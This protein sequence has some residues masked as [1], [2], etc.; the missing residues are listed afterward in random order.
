MTGLSVLF[1]AQAATAASIGFTGVDQADMDNIVKELS[2]NGSLHTVTTPSG[3]GSIFGFEVGLIAGLTMA[4]KMGALVKEQTGSDDIKSLPH[5]ALVGGVTI[6]FGLTV[7]AALVPSLDQGGFK[8]GQYAAAL[9]YSID[10]IPMVNVALRGFVASSSL[11]FKQTISSVE[12]T[13]T[14]DGSVMGLQALVSPAMIPIIEPY[15]GL[16][17]VSAKGKMSL[18]GGVT[19]FDPSLTTGSS[20]ESSPTSE[21]LLVGFNVR[22]F[23]ITL[24]AEYSRAFGAGSLTAKLSAG[25]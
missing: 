22:L 2:L 7:E 19:F 17:F 12:S 20:A 11:E 9:K 1:A 8:Y 14:Y 6:P 10:I 4:D 13:V 18:S 25:F 15:A 5:L 23:P 16:G 21:Q 24:G 3:Y